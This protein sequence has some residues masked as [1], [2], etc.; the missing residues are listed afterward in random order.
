MTHGRVPVV[1]LCHH[2][3]YHGRSTSAT[4]LATTNL[5]SVSLT[6]SAPSSSP[7]SLLGVCH[8]IYWI[9]AA[10][11]LHRGCSNLTTAKTP[12]WNLSAKCTIGN[13]SLGCIR[14]R[15]MVNDNWEFDNGMTAE[16]SILRFKRLD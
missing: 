7:A 6:A 1:V 2:K 11:H 16:A 13:Y 15:H 8:C 10:N 3:C 4:V 12:I 5:T 14:S 9:I